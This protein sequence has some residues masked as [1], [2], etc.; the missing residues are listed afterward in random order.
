VSPGGAAFPRL[1]SL[2]KPVSEWE[3]AGEFGA[4]AVLQTAELGHFG[5][6][7]EQPVQVGAR[8]GH[9]FFRGTHYFFKHTILLIGVEK[10]SLSTLY[11]F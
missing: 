5:F 10:M 4:G 1:D 6:V 3:Q 8:F 2:G 9:L 11:F 7:Q